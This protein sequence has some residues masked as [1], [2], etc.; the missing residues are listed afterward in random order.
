MIAPLDV[1]KIRLQLQSH[2]PPPAPG[3]VVEAPIFYKGILRTT[4]DIA[5]HEGITALWKGNV[6]AE[7]LYCTYGAA[8][9]F[10]YHQASVVCKAFGLADG[11][12]SFVAGAAAGGAATIATYPLDLLRTRFAA[13]GRVK[14]VLPL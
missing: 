8:Q 14:V 2:G 11:A 9:F 13:Q 1:V 4:R 12:T 7:F 10:A 3:N 6:P 5:R